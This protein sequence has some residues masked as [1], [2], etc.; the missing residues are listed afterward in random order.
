M[1]ASTWTIAGAVLVAAL[2]VVSTLVGVADLDLFILWE[3]RIPRTLALVLTGFALAVTGLLMQMLTRNRF[4]E[5]ST[6]GAADGA[7]LALLGILLVAPGM[8]LWAK[9][10]VTT[11]GA[12]VGVTGFLA[13]VRRIPAPSS[14]LVPVVGIMY[15]GIIGAVTT[16]LATRADLLQELG[17]WALGDFSSV[18][19][20]R[21]E[22]LWLAA[23][24]AGIAWLAADAFTLAGLGEDTAKGLGVDV[25]KVMVLGVAIIAVVT[26]VTTVTTGVIP[27]L[28][29][30]APH[31]VSRLVGDTMRRSVPL[32]GLLGAVIVL[33]CDILGRVVRYPY[34]IP[35][36]VIVGV[37]GALV[38]LWLLLGRSGRVRRA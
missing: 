13:L 32:V 29:L 19:R 8:P 21:Y 10:C 36:S 11:V 24:A 33:A 26:G 15:A 14:L 37:L 22:M 1:R 34:E 6:T 35:L 2:A 20:S 12:V 9:A 28:G 18:L 17:S 7:T 4:V 30:V 27:F 5:P 16:F 31:V 3:S 38:F 25:R 23:A